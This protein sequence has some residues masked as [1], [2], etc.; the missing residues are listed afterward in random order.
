MY[1]TSKLPINSI[2]PILPFTSVVKTLIKLVSN[3]THIYAHI[4]T[5]CICKHLIGR[6]SL[7]SQIIIAIFIFYSI[8][9]PRVRSFEIKGV[10]DTATLLSSFPCLRNNKKYTCYKCG[11]K[12]LNLGVNMISN[13]LFKQKYLLRQYM[14]KWILFHK[15]HKI[16]K[17]ISKDS[18]NRH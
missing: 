11:L 9:K 6:H 8:S 4:F 12:W 2:M 16:P 10:W 3:S 14:L 17:N 18:L 5:I 7:S 13:V 1:F 15:K